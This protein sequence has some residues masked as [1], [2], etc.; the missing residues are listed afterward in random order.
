MT[1]TAWFAHTAP[2]TP[3]SR[4]DMLRSCGRRRH[5]VIGYSVV[6]ELVFDGGHVETVTVHRSGDVD[7][8]ATVVTA[9]GTSTFQSIDGLWH[10]SLGIRLAPADNATLDDRATWLVGGAD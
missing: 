1:S 3:G 9:A 8:T 7:R 5:S 4:H 10:D 6:T 2:T